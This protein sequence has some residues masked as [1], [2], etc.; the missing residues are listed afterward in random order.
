MEAPFTQTDAELGRVLR[1]ASASASSAMAH[2]LAHHI[3]NPLQSITNSIFLALHS[4]DSSS[5]TLHLEQASEDLRQLSK[6]VGDLLLLHR[7][8]VAEEA[9]EPLQ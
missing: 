4:R 5:R 8:T 7:P 9:A 2:T 1:E 6:L 3:N